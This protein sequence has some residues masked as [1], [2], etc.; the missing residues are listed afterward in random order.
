[1]VSDPI[2]GQLVAER[3]SHNLTQ[4]VASAGIEARDYAPIEKGQPPVLA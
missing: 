1:M 3:A 2:P 4:E